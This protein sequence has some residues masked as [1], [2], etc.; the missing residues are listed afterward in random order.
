MREMAK[1][2]T[3]AKTITF[4]HKGLKEKVLDTVRQ[5]SDLV[6]STLGP[7]GKVVLIE[8]QE[9]LPPYTTKDGI[10]VFNSMAFSDPTAQAILE[11]ARDASSKTNSEAGDGTTTATILAE[12]LIRLGFEYL[13]KNPKL[14]TQKVMREL[15]AVY[16]NLVVPLIQQQAIKINNENDKDLLKK[17]ALISTNNDE[18]MSSAVL[19]AFNLVGHNGNITIA[20]TP[21][22]SGFDVEKIEGFPIARGFEDSCGRFLEEFI[23]DK[24]NYRTVLDKP[25]FILYNGKLNESS[26]LIPIL[27]KIV[28][29]T[30]LDGDDADSATPQSPNIV[31]VAHHFSE[32]VLAWF[33]NNFKNP[34]TL[35]LVPLKTPLSYQANGQYHFLLDLAAYTGAKVFDPMT[36]PLEHGEIEDLGLDS[37]QQFEFYRYKS[38]IIGRPDELMV[39]SRAEEL[40]IQLKHAESSLDKELTNERLGILT[41]GIARVKVMGSSEAELKEKKHRVEDAVCAIKGAL[42]QGVLPG[43][44]K[45]LLTLSLI[46]RNGNYSEAVKEIMGKAYLEPFYRILS[47]GGANAD[48]MRDV[49]SKMMDEN[50]PFFTTYDSLNHVHGPAVEMGIIDSA[51]AVLMAIKN[52][53]SVAKMLMGLSGIVVFKRDNEL[54]RNVAESNSEQRQAIQEALKQQEKEKW[55][56]PF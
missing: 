35:N 30:G 32:T 13:E 11:A 33:A 53:L 17:V 21:G 10:S 8:R 29:A 1:A 26:A 15:E 23:N 56:V 28:R 41:G 31:V 40:E 48:E 14:S 18:E 7:N 49:Y 51:E 20:E 9:D 52:S 47:N 43:G 42:R 55:E 36:N 25:R 37:M 22:S 2:K 6:G 5:A 45:T 16:K 38:L 34:E 44:A 4:E 3:A 46:I 39:I 12:A 27:Q 24:G 50:Q 19:D 54:D